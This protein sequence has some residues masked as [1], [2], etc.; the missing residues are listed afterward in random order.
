M[1]LTGRQPPLD[2]QHM[3]TQVLRL[4]VI[5]TAKGAQP[6]GIRGPGRPHR[7]FAARGD[8][9]RGEPRSYRRGLTDRR[10]QA[11]AHGTDEKM[12][13]QFRNASRQGRGARS[14]GMIPFFD[15]CVI[16]DCHRESRVRGDVPLSRHRRSETTCL[17]GHLRKISLRCVA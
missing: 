10:P 12:L 11:Q 8:L 13:E 7:R 5:V 2:Q 4:R 17:P 3:H 6:A 16:L 15:F 14:S 9:W 1:M